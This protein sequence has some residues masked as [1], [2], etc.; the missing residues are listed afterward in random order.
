[1]IAAQNTA[2]QLV[3]NS[4]HTVTHVNLAVPLFRYAP[5]TPPV[6]AHLYLRLARKMHQAAT[7]IDWQNCCHDQ[8]LSSM[9][10]SKCMR[11]DSHSNT[12]ASAGMRVEA[13]RSLRAVVM[14]TGRNHLI[15]PSTLRPVPGRVKQR[16]VVL[17]CQTVGLQL[18]LINC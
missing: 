11:S 9:W 14:L 2:G 18:G 4:C 6:T 8:A 7:S 1:M 15:A 5:G 10:R 16:G 13:L 17:G 3:A 12:A